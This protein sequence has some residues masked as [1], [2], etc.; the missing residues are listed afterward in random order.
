MSESKPQPADPEPQRRTV[1]R[2]LFREKLPLEKE[3][4]WF[5]LVNVLDFFAT[6]ILLRRGGIEESNPVARWFLDG[7]G[8]LKG[9]LFYKLALV[10]FICIVVQLIALKSE[11]T[12]KRVLYF[13]IVIVSAV[14]AYSAALILRTG[15]LL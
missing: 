10:T 14:V 9:L 15:A 4:C 7:W 3:T 6:Y 5:I 8:P 13:G 2:F 12:A 1:F 11:T